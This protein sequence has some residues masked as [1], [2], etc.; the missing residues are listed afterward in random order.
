MIRI[1]QA[2]LAPVFAA[3]AAL[4]ACSGPAVPDP[5]QMNA[6]YES[7]LERT[8]PL[9]V[10]LPA[11]GAL[12]Q[13]ESFFRNMSAAAVR[14]QVGLT[15]APEAYLNDNIAIVQGAPAIGEYFARTLDRVD[16]LQVVF[17]DV[18]HN[19]PEYFVRWRMTVTSPRF[20]DGAPMVSYGMTHFRFDERGRILVHKDFWDAGTGLYEYVPGLR[21]VL[22]RLRAAAENG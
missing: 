13:V 11:D 4:S 21:G 7:A 16:G 5:E 19:G 3:M 9:A 8:A 1:R 12:A 20:N 6:S 15:Y 22:R 17:L 18:M 14:A 2:C 10:E